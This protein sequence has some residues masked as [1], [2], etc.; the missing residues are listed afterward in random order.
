MKKEIYKYGIVK[1]KGHTEE[2]DEK[3]AYG[4][5]YAACASAHYSEEEC[6]STANSITKKIKKFAQSK[7]KIDSSE[8]RKRIESE[9][10]KKDEELAFFYEQHL[11]N[12]KRL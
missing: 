3:K 5:V 7:K 1:R 11:P 12:L 8:I 2:F 4:S 6:E 9:L 10:K